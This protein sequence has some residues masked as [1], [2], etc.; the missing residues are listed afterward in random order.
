MVSHNTNSSTSSTRLIVLH[1]DRPFVEF[2][3]RDR[4]LGVMDSGSTIALP[5]GKVR[6]VEDLDRHMVRLDIVVDSLRSGEYSFYCEFD[7]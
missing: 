3:W 2:Q 6:F 4:V 5:N 7:G 1:I